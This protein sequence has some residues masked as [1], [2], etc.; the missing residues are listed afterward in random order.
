M[1]RARWLTLL[2]A[3]LLAA[4]ARADHFDWYT[5]PVLQDAVKDGKC[6]KEFK[7]LSSKQIG[8]LGEVLGDTSAAVLIV[9]TNDDRWAKLLVQA[10]A[11]R[12]GKDKQVPMLLVEKYV[13]FKE[14]TER[15][16]KAR[17]ENL[18]LYPGTRLSLDIGQV[19]PE[20]LGGDLAVE[21]DGPNGFRVTPVK[22][23]KL[24]V[25]TK[26][27]PDVVPKKAPK[28]VVGATFETR[29]FNGKYRLFDDGR[30]SGKLNLEVN[31]SGE[32]TGSFYSD[33]DGAKYDVTGRVGSQRHAINFTIKFPQVEQTFTGFLFTGDGRAICGTTKLQDREAGFYAERLEE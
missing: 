26:P 21:E 5:N 14:A 6:I 27:I 22:G 17:G 24:Y 18:H 8:D 19:V 12:V 9:H 16:I 28:L 32:V 11:Q 20:K 13:T 15:T 3:L 29:Y 30:R 2:P 10:A 25:L 7:E 31:E 33:R 23:A 4:P 1:P